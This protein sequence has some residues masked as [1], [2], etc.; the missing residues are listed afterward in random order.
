MQEF[1]SS[2]LQNYP[3]APPIADQGGQAVNA[4]RGY[5]Y[6]IWV[7]ALAWVRLL[8]SQR[9]YLEVAQDFDLIANRSLRATQIKQSVTSSKVTLNRP[10]VRNA[11]IS[12]IDLQESNPDYDVSLRF[13]TTMPIG[14]ERDAAKCFGQAAGLEYWR[15]AG[16][17][18]DVVPIREYLESE[19]F[20]ES[21]RKYCQVLS[22]TELRDKLLSRI[23]WDCGNPGFLD[24]HDELI[25]SLEDMGHDQLD[26]S[27]WKAPVIADMLSSRILR[28]SVKKNPDLR[29][30][31]HGDLQGIIS[32]ATHLTI[33]EKNLNRLLSQLPH[34]TNPLSSISDSE[35][36]PLVIQ[37]KWLYLGS[38]LPQ[39][40]RVIKR[41]EI[42]RKLEHAI[43]AKG[44]A[45]L[46]GSIGLGK[47]TISRSFAQSHYDEFYIIECDDA[48]LTSIRH[49]LNQIRTS[50]NRF[51]SGI[52]ILDN[53]NDIENH[54]LL[55]L[56]EH[57]IAEL[58]KSNSHVLVTCHIQPSLT[59]LTNLGI[60]VQGVVQCQTFSIGE[61]RSLIEAYSG[62]AGGW[63]RSIYV[64][65]GTGHPV[66]AHALVASLANR[67]WPEN[68]K[69]SVIESDFSAPDLEKS[70][71]SIRKR[72]VS[73][74][75][76]K[77]ERALL[78][79]LS[80]ISGPFSRQFAITLSEIEPAFTCAGEC[81]DHLIGPWIE[82]LPQSHYRMS[83]L[84]AG[85][86]EEMISPEEIRRIHGCIVDEI[87][88]KA[89]LSVGDIDRVILH[90]IRAERADDLV[91]LA[92]RVLQSDPE[93]VTGIAR[94]TVFASW[95]TDKP[96][97]EKDAIA[98]VYMR[99][100]QFKIVEVIGNEDEICNV[101]TSLCD[102]IDLIPRG[103]IRCS[104]WVYAI[105]L[106]T[107]IH[108]IIN[109]ADNWLSILLR[110]IA[111]S[112]TFPFWKEDFDGAET[113]AVS[114]DWQGFSLIFSMGISDIQSA[115]RLEFIVD[116]LCESPP[117][118][119]SLLL[120]PSDESLSDH[121]EMVRGVWLRERKSPDYNAEDTLVRYGRIAEK[122]SDWKERCVSLQAYAVQASILDH[123]LGDPSRGLS[124]IQKAIN[125]CGS[126]P[127]L[128]R[129]TGQIYLRKRDLGKAIVVYKGL[130][131]DLN[132]INP[133]CKAHTFAEAAT[134]AARCKD[135]EQ[136]EKWFLA[137][138]HIAR[139]A[140][141]E[142]LNALSLGLKVDA[143]VMALRSNHVSRALTQLRETVD[144]LELLEP[145][146]SLRARYT[147]SM[148]C[149]TIL[150]IWS[151]VSN[152]LLGRLADIPY[153][154]C[155][156]PETPE[157]IREHPLAPIE[158]V[159]Y[160]LAETECVFREN[161]GIRQSLRQSI[162]TGCIGRLE[163]SLQT[164]AIKCRIEDLDAKGVA[165]CLESYIDVFVFRKET[166]DH[167]EDGAN[168]TYAIIEPIPK[169]PRDLY[170]STHV[171]E[172]IKEV[173][174]AF[175]IQSVFAGKFDEVQEL[176][177]IL[178]G[179]L[180][181]DLPCSY[182]F[183]IAMG[184]LPR[185]SNSLECVIAELI[186]LH[187]MRKDDVP[188]TIWDAGMCFLKWAVGSPFHDSLL[189]ELRRWLQ[190]HWTHIVSK[191]RRLS[192][193]TFSNCTTGRT[194]FGQYGY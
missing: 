133:S 64:R 32:S 129:S 87:T 46:T 76:I 125:Y 176:N 97:F 144:E 19:R 67:N 52:L 171:Q 25:R 47:S 175:L 148:V 83:P 172:A 16:I 182:L 72:I 74:L 61:I 43:K 23:S 149:H 24:I 109:F 116:Q 161:V 26:F 10:E 86:G 110:F 85:C 131:E 35:T 101:M 69:I 122:T 123:D 2:K 41:T 124:L 15:K 59:T 147:Y 45:M 36:N 63:D 130:V 157:A 183:E 121:F 71:A 155:S 185:K 103:K 60:D 34:S 179:Q 139:E 53:F 188:K 192:R 163:V 190:L 194:D 140:N 99:L 6:Q 189:R 107:Q 21:V 169:V 167:L 105:R 62:D 33:S 90:A 150:H 180:E 174:V 65:S 102:E 77:K 79:R 17:S 106:I 20:P 168:G 143:A 91:Y 84:I 154:L 118:S 184:A 170:S 119:R 22:N 4:L 141:M 191:R 37:N 42:E 166:L 11:I 27:P 50:I 114:L 142:G 173:I 128:V 39:R 89:I 7:T 98:S 31:T 113:T 80:L 127:I 186:C 115:T 136:A 8:P 9:I 164:T 134:A 56:I 38:D 126:H 145:E 44:L 12:F 146:T 66:L 48:N 92:I 75:P 160:L 159:W 137:G 187:S 153:G 120:K 58:R 162:P 193:Q 94:H 138:S 95:R 29:V 13:F 49:K 100:A 1:A 88:S 112:R 108:G 68:E 178:M 111:I 165:D 158:Y 30:L 117:E 78:Y 96:I 135:M 181:N 82:E 73:E 81:I 151:S 54:K 5:A 70:L 132:P 55:L 3:L 57:V 18:E 51:H 152:Q 156:A 14:R 28:Q 93:T 177:N 104:L 40:K